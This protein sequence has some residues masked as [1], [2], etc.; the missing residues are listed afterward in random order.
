MYARR[1]TDRRTELQCPNTP[2]SASGA[3]AAA[4]QSGR[5]GYFWISMRAWGY[6]GR[7][8]IVQGSAIC[9]LVPAVALFSQDQC[10]P[11]SSASSHAPGT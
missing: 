3:A 6:V 11:A 10:H 4:Q 7:L 8:P 5:F 9:F 2:P 1:S